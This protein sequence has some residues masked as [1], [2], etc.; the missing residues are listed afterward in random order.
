MTDLAGL[1]VIYSGEPLLPSP[2]LAWW[3]V[4]RVRATARCSEGNAVSRE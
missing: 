2:E 1:D 4:S 3:I